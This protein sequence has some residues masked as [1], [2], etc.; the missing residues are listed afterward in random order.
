[1][2]QTLPSSVDVLLVGLGPVGAT[3]ANLLGRYGVRTLVVEK[4]PD[5]FMAPRAIVLDNEALRILQMAGL[6]EGSFETQ[7]IA[8]VQMRSPIFGNYACANTSGPLDGHPRLVTFYQPDLER[9]LRARLTA[10]PDVQVALGAELIGIR[11]DAQGVHVDVR[12]AD[13]QVE[14]VWTRFLVGADGASSF[15]RRHA[16][17][18]FQG[19]TFEQDWLIVDAQNV[20]D[21]IDHVEFMCDPRRPTPHMPAPGNRQRWEF[22]LQP[23]ETREE[24]EKPESIR[25]LLAP[26]CK[27][28]DI[29]IERTAVYRF[30]ARIVDRFSRGRIFLVGDAAHIT[31]P[32]AGQGLVAGLRDVANLCWKLAWVVQGRASATIL[33]TYDIERRPHAKS[34]IELALFMG[35]LVMPANRLKAFG[36]HGLMWMMQLIPSARAMFEELRIKPKNQFGRGLFVRGRS[37]SRLVRGGLLPQ[38]L[39]RQSIG[40]PVQKSDDA[41]GQQLTLIGFGCDPVK[42]LSL[43]LRGEWL[44]AGGTLLQLRHRGQSGCGENSWEDLT[45]ALVP[46]AAPVGWVAVVRPDRT[47]LHDGPM[48]KVD[49]V[50][51]EALAVLGAAVTAGHIQSAVLEVPR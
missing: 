43:Q 25:K 8:K 12:M 15:V 11:E 29:S 1:M 51:S 41:I 2:R 44:S 47:V 4:S 24:M 39:V 5:I 7:A 31:P 50:V 45:D 30:H 16:G 13:G 40:A 28:E 35:S 18:I 3:A 20:P 33:D 36:I 21:P 23:G 10:Y 22:K 14:T 32:F 48:E 27:P 6:E 38:G 42:L 19:K 17:L 26:W 49:A 46:G 9:T 34:I 37:R